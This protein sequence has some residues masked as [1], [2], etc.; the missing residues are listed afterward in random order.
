MKATKK[1]TGTKLK[2]T[3][4]KRVSLRCPL[5]IEQTD[6]EY[7]YDASAVQICM[8]VENMGGGGLASDTVTSA[9]IVV[10]LYD[11]AGKLIPCS[12]DSEYFA[13]LLRFGEEGLLCGGRITFRLTPDCG[14]DGLRTEDVEVYISRVRCSDETVTD[15]VRGDFFDFPDNGVLISKQF[16][17]HE[18]EVMAALG[19]G[20][21]YVPE[22]LT[23][24][25]WRCTC[26]EF[27]ES[28]TCPSC[29]RNKAKLFSALA[30]FVG[31]N[32]PSAGVGAQ[33]ANEAPLPPVSDQTAEYPTGPAL[34][35]V[36]AAL[37]SEEKA[38]P[39]LPPRPKAQPKQSDKTKT[40]LLVSIV[41][42]AVVLGVLVLMLALTLLGRSKPAATTT[43]DSEVN[44]PIQSDAGEQIVRSYMKQHDYKNALGYAQSVGASE[45]LLD[46][47]YDAAIA[48]YT[49]QHLYEEALE[50][51]QLSDD[52]DVAITLR[53]ILF[54]Q[55]LSAEDYEG[56]I[57]LANTLPEGQR[58]ASLAEAANGY[59]RSLVA[60]GKYQ[61]AM[62]VA[63]QYRTELTSAQIAADAIDSYLQ[64]H[65]FDTAIALAEQLN[66]ADQVKECQKTAA[67][68]YIGLADYDRAVG[69]AK[70]TGDSALLETIF[71][72]LSDLQ[73]RRNLPAFFGFLTFE[74]K[75]AVYASPVSAN[76]QKIVAIDEEGNV[77]EG[78]RIVY[79][80]AGGGSPAVSV[81][82]SDT[83]IVALLE[84]GTV[85]YIKGYNGY[86]GTSD[87][88][89][90]TDIVA[91]AMSNYHILGLT[92]NG[93][94][95][96]AGKFDDTRCNVSA[97]SNAVAIA[98]SDNH[99]V[100]LFADGTVA[101]LGTEAAPGICNTADWTDIVAVSAGTLHT[102][103]LKSDGTAVSLGNCKVSDWSDVIAIASGG[104]NAVGVQ[105]NGNLVCSAAGAESD[106]LAGVPDA[107]WVSVGKSAIIVLHADGTLTS[108]GQNAPDPAL[109][110]EVQRKT[111]VFGMR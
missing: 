92:A 15:Y 3:K 75:Q 16:K 87:V 26:G 27:S 100:I 28:D 78:D 74:Q 23:E 10:R 46:E 61:E 21:T 7:N 105:S 77:Y 36:M 71:P 48:H 110:A 12:G 45:E 31:Q 38:P 41:A 49:E 107:V 94:V 103:G 47:I 89:G 101:A 1:R 58:E 79:Y 80:A 13:K 85:Y 63:D 54:S 106:L 72:H 39:V 67:E 29:G 65:E 111:E 42:A 69:Y 59:V 17:K 33:T 57:E 99:S 4:G 40:V 6:I 32:D 43:D 96:A 62:A 30:P 108:H 90:W 97:L 98:A 25:V 50:W 56:A 18:L 70:S 60:Q 9:V 11:G 68:F 35:A 37:D 8:T 86:F 91:I 34:A 52:E 55:K 88:N 95:V 93:E 66:L 102:V 44:E 24:I 14:P 76:P 73:I 53:A 81:A 2:L 64:N 82:S 22:A 5:S 109:L 104:N 51:A 19:T 84:N 83:T 20:A